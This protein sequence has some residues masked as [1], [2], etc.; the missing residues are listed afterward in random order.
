MSDG[1]NHLRLESF[2]P[3]MKELVGSSHRAARE[4]SVLHNRAHCGT[5]QLSSN[6]AQTMFA[7][8]SEQDRPVRAA[9]SQFR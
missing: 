1:D 8:I 6:R 3:D 5:S 7:L 9:D 2:L 4:S